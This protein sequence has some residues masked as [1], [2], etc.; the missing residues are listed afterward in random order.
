MPGEWSL[1]QF[2]GRVLPSALHFHDPLQIGIGR[3]GASG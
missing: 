2:T 3:G 1:L